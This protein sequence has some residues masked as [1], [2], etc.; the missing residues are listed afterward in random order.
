MLPQKPILASIVKTI[1]TQSVSLPVKK[2]KHITEIDP[3][4][5]NPFKNFFLLPA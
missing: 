5:Q 3:N 2:N 1:P 4:K